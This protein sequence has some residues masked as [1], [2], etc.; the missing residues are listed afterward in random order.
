MVPVADGLC[1]LVAG[2][3]LALGHRLWPTRVTG[4]VAAGVLA[5]LSIFTLLLMYGPLHRAAA[6]L[7]AV[8]IGFQV[9][10]I[11]APRF[12]QFM[13]IP[14]PPTLLGQLIPALKVIPSV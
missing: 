5:G 13:A 3:L 12:D 7:I 11:L 8:G 2:L 1:F 6:V 10:R 9:S 14:W 4:A